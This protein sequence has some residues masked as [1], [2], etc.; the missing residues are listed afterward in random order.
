MWTALFASLIM[1]IPFYF[2]TKG[3]LSTD[4]EKYN[5]FRFGKPDR[6]YPLRRAALGMILYVVSFLP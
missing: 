3:R 2:W 5:K 4:P 6:G 1:Y